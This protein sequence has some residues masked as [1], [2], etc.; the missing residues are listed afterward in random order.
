MYRELIRECRDRMGPEYVKNLE[1]LAKIE[2][3]Y[4]KKNVIKFDNVV[5]MLFINCEEDAYYNAYMGGHILRAWKLQDLERKKATARVSIELH[6]SVM[7]CEVD[8][9]QNDVLNMLTAFL[10]RFLKSIDL[11]DEMFFY[12]LQE[13]EEDDK[14]IL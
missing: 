8:G 13:V 11:S 4:D 10:S 2:E 5:K 1:D 9:D 12:F 14:K 3:E 6:D 7:S